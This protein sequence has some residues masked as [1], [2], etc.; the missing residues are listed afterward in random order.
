R[1]SSARPRRA[2]RSSGTTPAEL[3]VTRSDDHD[4]RPV[5]ERWADG[6]DARRDGRPPAAALRRDAPEKRL[7]RLSLAGEEERVAR[8]RLAGLHRRPEPPVE[9]DADIPGGRLCVEAA[10]DA[11]AAGTREE[12]VGR[13]V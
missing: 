2:S 1:Q 6:D 8:G 10:D 11:A 4:A 7:E 12:V 13:A 3:H 9:G 5:L